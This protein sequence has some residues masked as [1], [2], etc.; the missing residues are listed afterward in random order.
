MSK[1]RLLH[2]IVFATKHRKPTINNEHKRE[3]YAYIF[4]IITNHKCFLIRMNGI[5]D[6]LHI[7]IDLH[8]TIA[9]SSIVKDIKQSSSLWLKSN[10]DFPDFNGWNEG[11]YAVTLSPDNIESCKTYIINQERHHASLNLIEEV[12][13]FAHLNGLDWY[14]DDWE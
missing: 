5:E 4:G 7:L 14:P 2:H 11:Y 10:S 13:T 8:P 3:L 6:H 12:Q 1:T 9:L